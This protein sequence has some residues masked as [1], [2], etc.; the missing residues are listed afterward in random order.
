MPAV[1]PENLSACNS[2]AEIR[3]AGFEIFSLGPLY[4][5]VGIPH[6]LTELFAH[7]YKRKTGNDV[8]GTT[9][10][11]ERQVLVGFGDW[12]YVLD[13]MDTTAFPYFCNW[14]MSNKFTD[15]EGGRYFEPRRCSAPLLD[16][17]EVD[18]GRVPADTWLDIFVPSGMQWSLE[19]KMQQLEHGHA[20]LTIALGKRPPEPDVVETG[21]I[22]LEAI[23]GD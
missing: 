8:Y 2:F 12:D 6:S 21:K 14:I 4:V 13:V 15:R 17:I 16:P 7:D 3:K 20:P 5:L 10:R 23:N 19:P 1:V 9:M 18:G 22:T 11:F